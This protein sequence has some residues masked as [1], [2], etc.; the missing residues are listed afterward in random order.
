[1]NPQNERYTDNAASAVQDAERR[2]S[3]HEALTGNAFCSTQATITRRGY[4]DP[5]TGEPTYL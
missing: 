4:R 1:M 5:A 2:L 3:T